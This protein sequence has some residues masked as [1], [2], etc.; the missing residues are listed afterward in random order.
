M[1]RYPTLFSPASVG[2][3]TAKNRLV[4]APMVRNYAQEDGR[5]TPR[6]QAH[7]ERLAAGG[8]G[9]LI[10]EASYVQKDGRGFPEQLG[11]HH[12][13]V[14]EPLGRMV[15]AAHEH[16]ALIGP[17]L[18][19]A[20]RQTSSA[21]TGSQPVAPS[22][23]P[24]PLMG[25]VPRELTVEDIQ[26]I[27]TA[28]GEGARRAEQAG[29]DFVEIHGAHG[30]LLTQFLSPFTNKRDDAYG[31]DFDR[32]LRLLL[33][34]VAAVRSATSEG[35]PLLVRLS[36]D[37]MVPGG[38]TLEE[39]RRV[40]TELED[41]GV[42]VLDISAGNYASY[43]RG[44]MMA[45]MAREDG[46]L[47]DLAEE[48]RQHTSLPVIGVGK[49]RTPELAE[50]VVAEGHADFVAL[51]RSLLADPDWPRKAE[52]GQADRINHCIA[53]NQGCVARL[54]AG[55]DVWCTVNPACGFEE[56][57][58]SPAP[59]SPGRVLVIG[60]GPAGLQAALTAA[61][62][63]H[64]V[65][66]CE[67]EQDLGGQLWPAAATPLR[68]GWDELRRHLV[69]EVEHR[70]IEVRL[71][72]EVTAE[73]VGELAPDAVVLATGS[74]QVRPSLPGIDDDRVIT[75][76]ELL[77]GRR[78]A[79]SPVVVAGGGCSGAQTAEQLAELGHDVTLVEQLPG[80][81]TDAPIDDRSL[82]LQ[83]LDEAG[84]AA[85]T[86]TT[87][88][89]VRKGSVMLEGHQ[90]P[91]ELPAETVV[92]CLGARPMDELAERLERDGHRVWV[93]GDA[94]EPRKVTEAIQEGAR[95]A[96]AV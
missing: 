48:V 82:L 78:T 80:I 3:A 66:V 38:L 87:L 90:G 69:A 57:F 21:S 55:Q 77:E 46:V 61:D 88:M 11:I 42:D 51:G 65:L 33:E 4:M 70:D 91:E 12:D 58:A 10:L 37:E 92:L 35:F 15:E 62:R 28:F 25:E 16:G 59:I 93:V 50:Q 41:A 47:I 43:T 8:V 2:T 36:A 20:G 9:T 19:H 32:R 56:D 14:V 89:E 53:C 74:E 45:P 17:Q 73:M 13:G 44:Y 72:T 34:V 52:A 84:V 26:G 18:Y 40:A 64:R 94:V 86:E 71:G 79:I 29:C 96:L 39:T 30:Y 75:S 5:A 31:G 85:R 22:A 76:R 27:V 54:F 1:S 6:Y 67:R 24:D 60:G 23:I 83:R 49:I 63:G 7:V 68:D 81:A 95:A